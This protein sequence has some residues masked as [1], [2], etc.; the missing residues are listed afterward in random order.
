VPL[1]VFVP[2]GVGS[3]VALDRM[4]TLEAGSP[5]ARIHAIFPSPDG[6][7]V[8]VR[9]QKK[10]LNASSYVWIVRAADGHLVARPESN[11]SVEG[12]SADGHVVAWEYTGASPHWNSIQSHMTRLRSIDPA[13]GEFVRLPSDEHAAA[14]S[15]EI[16]YPVAA[17]SFRKRASD[18]RWVVRDA[19][20]NVDTPFDDMPA[21]ELS[22]YPNPSP[23][24]RYAVVE[25]RRA[26]G[27]T[28]VLDLVERRVIYSSTDRIWLSW[29]RGRDDDRFALVCRADQA[30][31]LIDLATEPRAE[32]VPAVALHFW[33]NENIAAAPG[34]G[35]FLA[36]WIDDGCRVDVVDAQ[37]RTIRRVYPPDR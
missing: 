6:K 37:C 29:I 2:V 16:A 19:A 24:G 15:A 22:P 18:G 21:E 32:T 36:H 3:A 13:T 12:W 11:L 14:V 5:D 33:N 1:A 26:K 8:A 23:H 9:V 34:D 25:T 31:R 35:F 20:T 10:D 30:T 17:R 27:S 7:Y 28:W 4:L